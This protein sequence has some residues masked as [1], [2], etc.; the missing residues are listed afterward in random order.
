MIKRVS[1]HELDIKNNIIEKYELRD[2]LFFDIE[3]LGFDRKEKAIVLLSIGKIEEGNEIT[4]NQFFAENE[5]EE[6]LILREA[7]PYFNDNRIWCS[8]NGLAFDEP[9][10]KDRTNILNLTLKTPRLHYDIFRK[11]KPYA[12]ALGLK[13]CNLKTV[14]EYLGISRKD[15]ITGALSIDLYLQYR[16]TGD[17][18]TRDKIMLHN[19]EDVLNLP[20]LFK[21]ID[22]INSAS[23]MISKK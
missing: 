13:R 18:I 6:E 17:I 3:T 8:Y 11:I 12:T 5:G 1:R 7:L 20:I 19:Y 9:F 15:D 14:E 22:K 16:E 10:L 2:M 23:L 4:I 21:V